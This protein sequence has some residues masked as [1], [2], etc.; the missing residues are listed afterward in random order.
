MAGPPLILVVDDSIELGT[1][2]KVLGRRAGQEVVL[3]VDAAAGWQFLH[4]RMPDLLLLD[5]NLPGMSGLGLCRKIRATPGL[6]PVPVALF[7]HWQIPE[8]IVAGL[9][10]GI[11][12]LV[13]KE[14]VTQP[15]SWQT[16]LQEILCWKR[17]QLSHRMVSWLEKT[18]LPGLS[19]N[20][21][22]DLNRALRHPS[23]KRLRPHILRLLLL[24]SLRQV[25]AVRGAEF[26]L[27]SLL[28][29]EEAI[30]RV[31]YFGPSAEG[32]EQ[33]L[34]VPAVV[35]LVVALAEQVWCLLGTEATANFR[36]IL[37]SVVAGL[38]ELLAF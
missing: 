27:E 20:W 36:K 1:I 32:M 38:E 7:S 16:R 15:E 13:S 34:I 35:A 10:A 18:N 11:D 23:V 9:Q 37:T 14:L 22:D 25:G 26:D 19:D 29:P 28:A 33:R 31:H 24:R 5:V 8:D 6:S 17:G 3:C 2:V 12:F 30:F 21:L 4:G